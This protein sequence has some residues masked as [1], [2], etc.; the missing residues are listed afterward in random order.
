MRFDKLKFQLALG[1]QELTQA[2]LAEKIHM[3]RGNLSMIVN[4]KSCQPKTAFKIAKGLDVDV[5]ELLED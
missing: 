5:T 2:E 3:S 1:K 4:G